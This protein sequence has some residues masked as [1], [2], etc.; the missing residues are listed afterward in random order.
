MFICLFL[1]DIFVC[2]FIC[3]CV[4]FVYFILCFCFIFNNLGGFQ[5]AVEVRGSYGGSRRLGGWIARCEISKESVEC[6][7]GGGK[8]IGPCI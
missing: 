1:V 5:G 8:E 3:F 2:I 7:L 6:V 4:L